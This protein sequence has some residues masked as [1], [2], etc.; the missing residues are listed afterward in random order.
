MC[1]RPCGPVR[2]QRVSK[3]S[4]QIKE[5][6]P[7]VIYPTVGNIILCKDGKI[8]VGKHVISEWYKEAVYESGFH[9]RPICSTTKMCYVA[10]IYDVNMVKTAKKKALY[11]DIADLCKRGITLSK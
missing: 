4:S 7:E 5:V 9:Y 8:K 3:R 10:S 1:M 11:Q 6:T 2:D